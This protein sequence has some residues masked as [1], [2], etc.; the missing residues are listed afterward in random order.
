MVFV[1]EGT[2][3]G[4]NW[5]MEAKTARGRRGKMETFVSLTSRWFACVDKA[6]PL[7][8]KLSF[9]T[10]SSSSPFTTRKGWR[11]KEEKSTKPGEEKR[12]T[13]IFAG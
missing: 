13:V 4:R 9:E 3:K 7:Q 5:G 11:K 6:E 8:G 12:R 2:R 10:W 1:L